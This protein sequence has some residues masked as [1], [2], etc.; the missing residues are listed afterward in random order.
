MKQAIL[1]LFLP[2]LSFSQSID[3]KVVDKSDNSPMPSVRI[4][5]SE[6]NKAISNPDGTFT[7]TYSKIPFQVIVT[8]IS[9]KT[10]TIL[11]SNTSFLEI[12]MKPEI[13][14]IESLGVGVISTI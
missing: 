14:E 2:F 5:T 1:L 4:A 11:V 6:G 8:S 13:E 10:D 12:K 9:F 3:G 7:I